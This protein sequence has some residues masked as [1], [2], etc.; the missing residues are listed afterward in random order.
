MFCRK[1]LLSISLI[2]ALLSP[3]M[4][5]AQATPIIFERTNIRIDPTVFGGV[6]GE[7]SIL[8]DPSSFNIELRSEDALKLE[9]IHTLNTL[10]NDTGV[11]ILFNA[12]LLAPLPAMQVFTPVDALFVAEDGRIIQI[13]PNVALGEMTQDIYAKEHVKAFLFL[14]AGQ[15]AARFIQPHDIVTGSMFVPSPSVMQ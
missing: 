11:M 2:T 15:V 6:D 5:Y 7:A 3:A 13:L 12:P 14:A 10:T 9:Y 4:A 1:I 8:R